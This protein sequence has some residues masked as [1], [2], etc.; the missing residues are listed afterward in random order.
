MT[1][2]T[3]QVRRKGAITLPVELRRQYDLKEGDVLA[4]FDLGDGS[5]LLTPQVSQVDILA[6][7]MARLTG[8]G[9]SPITPALS[10][11]E[12]RTTTPPGSVLHH[13]HPHLPCLPHCA[14]ITLGYQRPGLPTVL[15]Q[16]ERSTPPCAKQSQN[17][18]ARP[19]PAFSSCPRRFAGS[20]MLLMSCR[21]RIPG[22]I[23][24][25]AGDSAPCSCP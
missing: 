9:S 17:S 3:V 13:R 7:Q 12:T 20:N 23:C 24:P 5:F 22:R 11:Y 18:Y 1:T 21:L 15:R 16:A 10:S 2:V 25:W 14:K 8:P 19:T 4:L 6:D